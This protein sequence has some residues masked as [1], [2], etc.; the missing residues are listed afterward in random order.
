MSP[1]AQYT[2]GIDI[3]IDTT[4]RVVDP[5]TAPIRAV[6]ISTVAG[7]ETFDGDE[8]TILQMVDARLAS[9]PAGV[10]ATWNGAVF[11][12][13][14]IA[15]RAARL[16]VDVALVLRPDPDRRQARRP[17][18]GH[19]GPQRAQWGPHR[20]LDTFRLYGDAGHANSW[21]TLLGLAR[22]RTATVA[23]TDDLLHE[24]LHA[25]AASDA[26]LARALAERRGQGA[27]RFVDR[28]ELDELPTPAAPPRVARGPRPEPQGLRPAIAGV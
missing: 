2:Y 17:L 16:G 10:L 7:D 22:R 19:D 11:D 20:H 3:E 27:L 12:L 28:I 24:A 13:P 18:P 1:L 9:L 15:D 26:R 25:H 21:T 4:S 5:A 6:A 8:A 14:Y 23:V